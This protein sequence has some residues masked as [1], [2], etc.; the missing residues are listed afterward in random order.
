MANESYLSTLASAPR[1]FFLATNSAQLSGLFNS[2]SASLCRAPTNVAATGPFD[3]TICPGTTASLSVTVSNCEPSAYQWR[4][5]GA[6]ITGATAATYTIPSATLADAGTYTAYVGN[7]AGNV[8]SNGAV[9]IV[10]A[11]PAI[12]TQPQNQSVVAGQTAS[13][14]VSASGFPVPTY[15]WQKNSADIAGATASSY[16]TP[17]TVLGDSGAAESGLPRKHG[18]DQFFGYLN[19]R[20]AHNH[21]PDFLWRNEDRVALPNVVTAVGGDGAGYATKAVQFAD[22]LF[23]DEAIEFVGDNKSRPFFLYWSLVI[24]HANNERARELK[25][26]AHVPDFGPYADQDWPAPDTGQAAMISRLDGTL[27]GC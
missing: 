25:N 23:A 6:A 5:D 13:F 8:T 27:A 21:F 12:T 20:H 16:T 1:D 18:F 24:P 11:A 26:G 15:Q 14:S 17:A 4:K 19:Q 7:V 10:N 2:I 22:D 9:L 3:V